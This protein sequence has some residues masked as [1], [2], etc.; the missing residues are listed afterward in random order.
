MKKLFC[1]LAAVSLLTPAFAED[2]PPPDQLLPADTLGL[3]TVPDMTTARR[4]NTKSPHMLLWA[5]PS[6]KAF[7]D[8]F[9]NK[10]DAEIIKPFEQK[11]GIELTNYLSLAQGQFTIAITRNG[12]KGAPG[13]APG[14][15]V[16]IDSRN[17]SARM[18]SA[19]DDLLKRWRENGNS[20]K[21][22]TI[23]GVPFSVLLIPRDELGGLDPTTADGSA[24][25]PNP[26]ADADDQEEVKPVELF[27]GQSGSLF[28]A[29]TARTDLE[30]ILSLQFGGPVMALAESTSFLPDYNRSFRDAAVYGWLNFQSVA[31]A[32]QNSL[33]TADPGNPFAF[34]PQKV[35]RTTGISGIRTISMA[36]SMQTDGDH[37]DFSVNVP[38]SERRGLFRLLTFEAKDS[39]PPTFVPQDAVSFVRY[40]LNMMK[41][42]NALEAMIAEISPQLGGIMKM[43]LEAVGKDKDATFDFRRM[44]V[45]NLGDDLLSWQKPP[46]ENTIEAMISQPEIVLVGSPDANQLSAALKTLVGMVPPDLAKLEERDFLGRKVWSIAVPTGMPAE[47]QTELPTQT[48][49]FS[50]NSGYLAVATDVGLLEEFLRSSDGG[51]EPLI[52]KTGLRF[53]TEKI[54]GMNTGFFGYSNDRETIR[55]IYKA[56][57]SNEE[58]LAGGMS[59]LGQFLAAV[60]VDG[61]DG[62]FD[63]WIDLSLL[64]PFGQIEKYFDYTVYS[65]SVKPEGYLLRMFAPRPRGL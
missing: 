51:A 41:S 10:L 56:L 13:T 30:K 31:E 34:N 18:K 17:E 23:R 45:Q 65:G 52:N 36:S 11:S 19:V 42:W 37:F 16:L 46:R 2:V 39:A 27:V 47:G 49:A 58:V 12:W 6:L 22:E 24:G 21:T 29:S 9:L 33:P 40:R 7:K 25:D 57:T 54:G 50:S 8:K 5:D 26:A 60:N 55:H 63:Q 43:T 35:F 53:A 20:M 28:L 14:V 62:E 4:L 1:A 15:V 44:F 64:P 48:V 32:V 59:A 61:E 38:E 3:L